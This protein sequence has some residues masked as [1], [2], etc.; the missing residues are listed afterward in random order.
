[1]SDPTWR[2][3]LMEEHER[4]MRKCEAA[5]LD[6]ETTAEQFDKLKAAL[7]DLAR[8]F[9]EATVALRLGRSHPVKGVQ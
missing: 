7:R 2:D 5:R 9:R 6:P 1:M 3:L 4:L 8:R